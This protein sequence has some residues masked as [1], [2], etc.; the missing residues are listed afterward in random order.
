M[1]KPPK[2]RVRSLLYGESEKTQLCSLDQLKEHF[3]SESDIMVV[4]EGQ[5]INSYDELNQLLAKGQFKNK[6]LLEVVLLPVL[7]GG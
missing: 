7:E 1:P 3:A 4:V 5:I 2:L 6:E